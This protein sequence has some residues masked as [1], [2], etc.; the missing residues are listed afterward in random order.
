MCPST[1]AQTSVTCLA[2]SH[3]SLWNV[4]HMPGTVPGT[5]PYE[6]GFI[7]PFVN[8]ETEAQRGSLVVAQST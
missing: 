3:L 4:Y 7:A 5:S 1:C 8:K 6:I 2:F